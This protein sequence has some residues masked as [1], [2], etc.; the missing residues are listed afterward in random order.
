MGESRSG[1]F[2]LCRF[3]VENKSGCN[4]LERTGRQNQ[5]KNKIPQTAKLQMMS[6]IFSFLFFFFVIVFFFFLFLR[7]LITLIHLLRFIHCACL[8]C[9]W[10]EVYSVKQHFWATSVFPLHIK[11]S[12]ASIR[13]SLSSLII[14][15]TGGK[16]KTYWLLPSEGQRNVH[17]ER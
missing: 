16:N 8:C 17:I 15:V 5:T 14:R 12:V 4:A 13:G 3:G 6:D 1:F 7:K 9:L 11:V 10:L 2:R